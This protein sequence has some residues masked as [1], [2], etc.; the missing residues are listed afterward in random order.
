MAKCLSE[1]HLF[2]V[3]E[4]SD[5]HNAAVTD[6]LGDR[7]WRAQAARIVRAHRKRHG[8][9][10]LRVGK[11]AG[12]SRETV[13][14]I[15][16]ADPTIKRSTLLDVLAVFGDPA[17]L[18]TARQKTGESDPLR[19]TDRLQSPSNADTIA[20][21]PP[22]AATVSSRL[23]V[24]DTIIALLELAEGLKGQCTDTVDQITKLVA[25]LG[26]E[27]HSQQAPV[28]RPG[29]SGHARTVRADHRPAHGKRRTKAS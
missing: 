18:F 17:E 1:C 16:K 26:I 13:L 10:Q 3:S 21:G 29:T 9:N 19:Q 11:A 2:V 7:E 5:G 20:K 4:I 23:V 27:L 28:V 15:E 8:W 22:D 12:V 24:E 14:R 25:D 6:E